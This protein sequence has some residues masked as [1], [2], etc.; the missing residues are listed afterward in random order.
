M[1]QFL[2]I[3]LFP[4]S[5][6]LWRF[7]L[8]LCAAFWFCFVAY[9]LLQLAKFSELMSQKPFLS[10]SYISISSKLNL[11][12]IF[13]SFSDAV[14]P[15]LFG[16]LWPCFALYIFNEVGTSFTLFQTGF[17]KGCYSFCSSMCDGIFRAGFE[18]SSGEWA[19][20]QQVD[21]QELTF[22]PSLHGRVQH[23]I[24][25]NL[26]QILILSPKDCGAWG[27]EVPCHSCLSFHSAYICKKLLQFPSI[28]VDLDLRCS[29]RPESIEHPETTADLVSRFMGMTF[30]LDWG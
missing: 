7:L 5:V 23:S 30:I 4:A 3:V 15:S 22:S 8:C 20:Y 16:A 24:W 17:S 26:E 9:I 2:G 11:Y 18:Q 6:F 25:G 12:V 14:V 27:T 1:F 28:R 19:W 10:N 29:D 13:C 21:I